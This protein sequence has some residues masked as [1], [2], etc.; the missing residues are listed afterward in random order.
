MKNFQKLLAVFLLAIL[1]S[2]CAGKK[3]ELDRAVFNS[4][5]IAA[6]RI[7]SMSNTIESQKSGIRKKVGPYAGVG[8]FLIS[9]AIDRS[10]NAQRNRKIAPLAEALGD[11]DIGEQVGESLEKH[12][13]GNTF[14]ENLAIDTNFDP[15]DKTKL[16]LVPTVIPSA[17][18]SVDYS[19]VSVELAVQTYQNKSG[20]RPS[21]QSYTSEYVLDSQGEKVNREDNFQFWTDNPE[22]LIEQVNTLIDEA[23]VK[24]ALDYNS[25]TPVVDEATN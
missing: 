9:T 17:I 18:M 14:A 5:K 24:F 19:T 15:K 25:P 3:I 16:Y 23:A 1:L 2:A 11:Y 20:K 6:V 4:Q 21:S 10:T 12:L 8:G 7:D 13:K 22:L